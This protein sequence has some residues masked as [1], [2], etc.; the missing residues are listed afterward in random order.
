MSSDPPNDSTEYAGQSGRPPSSRAQDDFRIIAEAVP[1]L[2]WATEQEGRC[3]FCNQSWYDF[4][5]QSSGEALERGWLDAVHPDD[6]Q[7]T[8]DIFLDAHRQRAPIESQY[9]LRHRDGSWRWVVDSGRPRYG[10][11]GTFLGFVGAVFDV[12]DRSMAQ[13]TV[14]ARARQQQAVAELGTVALRELGSGGAD[15]LPLMERTVE[16]V[17]EVLAVEMC[18][19]LEL[20]PGG[21]EVLLLAGVGWREGLVGQATVDTGANSQAGYTL[22]SEEPVVVEDL[23]AETRFNGP[24]LLVEHGVTSGIS[25]I[26]TGPD[27]KPWGVLG[28]HTRARRIFSQDDVHFLQAVA[29]LLGAA[30]QRQRTLE[31]R[32]RERMVLEAVLEALPVGV[33]ITDAEGQI[34]RTNEAT[35]EL[36]GDSP[37]MASWQEYTE[38]VAW[39]PDTGRRVTAEEWAMTRALLHG[40]VTRDELILNRKFGGDDRRFYLNNAAPVR[41]PKGHIIG[42]VAAMLDVTERLAAERAVREHKE[43]LEERVL[44]RTRQVRALASSL[45]RAEQAERSRIAQVLHDDV[46]QLLY[47]L[48]IQVELV[49]DHIEGDALDVELIE[50]RRLLQHA[51]DAT[52]RLTLTTNPPVLREE[53]LAAALTWLAGEMSESFP[54]EVNVSLDL[55]GADATSSDERALVLHTVRELLFNVVKHAG[56]SRAHVRARVREGCLL[57]EVEDDGVGFDPERAFARQSRTFGLANIRERLQLNGGDITIHTEPRAGT[58]ATITLP[59]AAG[60]AEGG[61]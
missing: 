5:G 9:R 46:Q 33:I 30:L 57:V 54:L 61:C 17:S 51:I 37:P 58:R 52:R 15:T 24:P 38:F 43:Q 60:G 42:G 7:R 21:E 34:V 11:D 8:R 29:N 53:G 16:T 50:A 45:S 25:C 44:E 14:A 3:T 26:I 56:V 27:G 23:R 36:W 47:A 40:D 28:A 39:W 20:L 31:D 59:L 6:R 10:D 4:T 13:R 41:D 2:V 22:L 18:K 55:H 32:D 48:K 19:V 12:H 49:H 1:A 35:R